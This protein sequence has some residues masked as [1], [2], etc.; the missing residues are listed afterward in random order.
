MPSLELSL[1]QFTHKIIV[2]IY[3][4][5]G[6]FV[7]SSAGLHNVRR[8]KFLLWGSDQVSS[9]CLLAMPPS[10]MAQIWYIYHTGDTFHCSA[11]CPQ[12]IVNRWLE[13]T[14]LRNQV[15]HSQHFESV[16]SG[17]RAADSNRYGRVSW[18]YVWWG[19]LE[20]EGRMPQEA[21]S[22]WREK[23]DRSVICESREETHGVYLMESFP[24]LG[25]PI[26]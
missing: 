1:L 20:K 7:T 15:I 25:G 2:Q 23:G 21:C 17:K 22:Q 16:G 11:N 12:A 6:S 10:R 14:M 4:S 26:G 13:F 19:D 9:S 8:E 24:K 3:W 5:H 18:G